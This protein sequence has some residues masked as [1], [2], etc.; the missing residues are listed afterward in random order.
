MR[1]F[2]RRSLIVA[3]LP[4]LAACGG[5]KAGDKCDTTGFLCEN[6]TNALECKLGAWVE[7]P[8]KGTTGCERSGEVVKCDMSGNVENDACA[9]S[10]EGKGLCTQDGLA[11]LECRDGKLVKTNDCRSCT[12]TGETVVCQP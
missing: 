10:A 3:V 2:F 7:L 1:T 12:V 9:S 6:A 11:T 4:L 8:C 5:A